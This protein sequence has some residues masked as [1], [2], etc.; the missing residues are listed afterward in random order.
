MGEQ[1]Q[2][3]VYVSL[4]AARTLRKFHA[5]VATSGGLAP[6]CAVAEEAR[7]YELWSCEGLSKSEVADLDDRL[8]VL[9]RVDRATCVDADRFVEM[10]RSRQAP[11]LRRSSLRKEN[12]DSFEAYKKELDDRIFNAER[13][14][15]DAFAAAQAQKK[16][17]AAA[18]SPQLLPKMPKARPRPALP[19]STEAARKEREARAEAKLRA[20]RLELEERDRRARRFDALACARR[21]LEPLTAEEEDRVD[22][23]LRARDFEA[24]QEKFNMPIT[25]VQ[26][27]R[28]LPKQWLVDEL[29]NFYF[30]LMEQRDSKLV[31]LKKREFPEEDA[32]SSHFF[33][34]FFFVKLLGNDGSYEYAGVRRWTKRFDLFAKRFVFIP[35][36]VGNMHWTLIMID[37][38]NKIV[39]YFDSMAGSGDRYLNATF[40]Y[41]Q[42]EHK[43]KK[44]APLLDLDDWTLV[45]TTDNTPQQHNGYDCGVFATFCAHWM[46]VDGTEP[47]FDQADVAHLRRRMMLSILD[48]DIL[49]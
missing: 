4:D 13:D 15:R 12:D 7:Q 19:R 25:G 36:N 6:V 22:A 39:R 21:C 18:L 20:L 33:N 10:V 46:A 26:S 1:R 16:K 34:S 8:R 45:P 43:D 29:I 30:K 9:T 28:L 2:P 27:S 41:L 17:I 48:V 42:D 49:I 40:R 37:L 11:S 5:V 35:V 14:E 38:P 32:T 24:V 31:E 23:A 3:L 47:D 44:K